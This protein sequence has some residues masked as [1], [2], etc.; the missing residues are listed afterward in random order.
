MSGLIV[1]TCYDKFSQMKREDMIKLL[2]TENFD[3][4][5]PILASQVARYNGN[6]AEDISI[7]Y[8]KNDT[9]EFMPLLDANK[10]QKMIFKT[11]INPKH[12]PELNKDSDNNKQEKAF[13]GDIPMGMSVFDIYLKKQSV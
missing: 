8:A 1:K 4:N 6:C 9:E 12:V 10:K 2:G 3:D 5:T 7:F 13:T 11:G